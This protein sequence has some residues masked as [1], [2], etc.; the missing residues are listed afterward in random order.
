[1]EWFGRQLSDEPIQALSP[2][3]LRCLPR[4]LQCPNLLIFLFALSPCV[5]GPDCYSE[6]S[7]RNNGSKIFH[8]TSPFQPNARAQQ[9]KSAAREHQSGYDLKQVQLALF[10][11][12]INWN[13]YQQQ[14]P[15]LTEGFPD[16]FRL[17]AQSVPFGIFNAGGG[18]LKMPFVME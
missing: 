16:Q 13:K 1:L 18:A 5:K 10:Q 8:L 14:N 6:C 11:E 4:V 3:A 2:W 9:P 7:E 17:S 15:N 12:G